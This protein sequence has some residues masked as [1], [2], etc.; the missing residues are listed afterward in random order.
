MKRALIASVVLLALGGVAMAQTATPKQQDEFQAAIRNPPPYPDLDVNSANGK[1]TDRICGFV[2]PLGKP[3]SVT[4]TG[5]SHN[6]MTLCMRAA[7]DRDVARASLPVDSQ[8]GAQ[9]VQ[10][11]AQLAAAEDQIHKL[12]QYIGMPPSQP[13]QAPTRMHC[14]PSKLGHP[15]AGMDC[16]QR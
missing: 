6:E 1:E 5:L 15:S 4:A 10:L 3:T 8:E 11:K 7:M 16:T 2:S 9:I 12:Q 13:L 14:E